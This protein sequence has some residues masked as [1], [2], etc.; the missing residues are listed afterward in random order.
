MDKRTMNRKINKILFG[1]RRYKPENRGG[2]LTPLIAQG[3]IDEE[4]EVIVKKRNN[5]SCLGCGCLIVILI[6]AIF[7]ISCFFT[8]YRAVENA[9]QKH[10]STSSVEKS[11]SGSA[12]SPAKTELED[13][14]WTNRKDGRTITGKYLDYKDGKASVLRDNGKTVTIPL[15]LLSDE[16]REYIKSIRK[17]DK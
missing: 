9:V 11:E 15:E 1:D 14:T 12:D 13:R 8:S 7:L 17:Q 6:V 3:D 16:D 4:Y 5:N 2:I 10:S